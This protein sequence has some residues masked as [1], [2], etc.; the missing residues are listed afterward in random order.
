[1][2]WNGL[3]KKSKIWKIIIDYS[4]FCLK[5]D[6]HQTLVRSCSSF[7]CRY[8]LKIST[9]FS[10]R[11]QWWL[12]CFTAMIWRLSVREYWTFDC[13]PIILI[14]KHVYK[15]D[16]KSLQLIFHYLSNRKQRVDMSMQFMEKITY[17]KVHSW[18]PYL[19]LLLVIYS[20]K[21][22][23]QLLENSKNHQASSWNGLM[24]IMWR[25][26]IITVTF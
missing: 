26:I 16:K 15:L 20:T 19:I 21:L 13:L 24:T 11:L 9:W 4:A 7:C 18:D 12:H 25:L 6:I 5:Y 23:N 2:V 1:M 17:F 8:T 14:T 10:T 3:T 22:K